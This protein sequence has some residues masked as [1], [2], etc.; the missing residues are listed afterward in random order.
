ASDRWKSL[1]RRTGFASA[2]QLRYS[3][4]TKD[5][6]YPGLIFSHGSSRQTSDNYHSLTEP[7]FDIGNYRYTT[8]SGKEKKTHTWG[9]LALKLERKLPQMVLD[10]RGNNGLLGGSTLPTSF[11][12]NQKL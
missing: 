8:G 7:R 2:N 4:G 11:R 5:P 10:A 9:Y 12:G 3:P 6:A 1:L